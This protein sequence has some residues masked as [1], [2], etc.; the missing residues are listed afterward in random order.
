M[1]NRLKYEKSPYLLQH[2]DNPVDWYPWSRDAFEKAKTENKPIFLSIG[3]STCHWCHV[4]AHESFE[5]SEVADILNRS[6]V[7]VKVDREERPDI[8]A[9]YMAVCQAVTGSGGWPLTIIMTPEQKPFFAATYLPKNGRFGQAGLTELLVYVS[10]LWADETEKKKLLESAE[11]ITEAVAGIKN[12][13]RKNSHSADIFGTENFDPH[14]GQVRGRHLHDKQ[15]Q[16][17]PLRFSE[18]SFNNELLEKA[19]M[20]FASRFD[21][22]YGGFGSAPKFPAPHNLIFL[23]NYSIYENK[24]EACR[25]ALAT[26][27]AMAAGG[28]C[29]QIGGGFSRYSTD[30]KWLA[31]HFEKMLYDNALLLSAYIKAY[32]LTQNERYADIARRTADYMLR[33]LRDPAGGFYCAQDADSEGVE[34]KYYVFTPDEVLA[35]LGEKDGREFCQTYDIT[36]AGNFEGKSIPNLIANPHDSWRA[37]DQR[38]KK[39]YAYRSSRMQL[40]KD[41]KV[42]SSWTSFAAAAFAQAGLMLDNAHYLE[43]AKNAVHFISENMTDAR[44]RLF[45]SWHKNKSHISPSGCSSSNNCGSNKEYTGDGQLSDY[46]A[47]AFSLLTLY[48]TTL[49]AEY[50]KQA[51]AYAHKIIELFADESEGGFFQ[52]AF[53]AEQ[54][55]MRPKEVYDGAIPSGNSLV[56][57]IFEELAELTGEIFWRKQADRQHLFT[58]SCAEISPADFSFAMN[59][60]MKASYPQRELICACASNRIPRE[61]ESYMRSA[62]SES[63]SIIFKSP[64]NAKLLAECAPFTA[65][66]PL[67]SK[68]DKNAASDNAI[69]VTWYLCNNG[70]CTAPVADFYSL[71]L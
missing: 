42:L 18:N 63:T 57:M 68:N 53:D 33:E 19:Y 62:A 29:D 35:V 58:A 14:S 1:S 41:D 11:R 56:A 22:K 40:H 47:Y 8:D 67:P 50:L 44:G 37:D 24:T 31:P 23:M 36:K 49:S 25:M 60:L 71:D 66:Y 54:L 3:Y 28:I 70:A 39:L 43:T 4:M 10:K 2:A 5:D 32:Q 26:L 13:N 51:A 59:A 55:I 38:L 27:D 20:S 61:L 21:K 9:V 15:P 65:D 48:K 30:E 34:G 6:F 64:D 12:S 52:T 17:E 69:S 46:A 16:F 45:V 7:S